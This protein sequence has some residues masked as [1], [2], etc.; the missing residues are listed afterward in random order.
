MILLSC[1]DAGSDWG[2]SVSLRA[3][4]F[5]IQLACQ[6]LL[7]SLILSVHMPPKR[8][9][10]EMEA[11]QRHL[12]TAKKRRLD[13]RD[14]DEAVSRLL[15]QHW[16][17]AGPQETDGIKHEGLTLRGALKKEKHR[18]R[19]LKGR[20]STQVIK[21]LKSKY[22]ASGSATRHLTVHDRTQTVCSDHIVG[23]AS[24]GKPRKA[25]T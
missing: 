22:A 11:S 18:V 20:I 4:L 16:P 8:L 5:W 17:H 25:L 7:P 13:R 23:E 1:Q 12:Q 19:P 24:R 21:R 10:D 3:K 14:T 6:L 2:L 15:Q 9:A